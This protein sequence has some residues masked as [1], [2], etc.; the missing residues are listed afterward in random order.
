MITCMV[1]IRQWRVAAAWV[2]IALMMPM[3]GVTQHVGDNFLFQGLTDINPVSARAEAMGNAYT[4]VPLDG[5]SF[6]WNP[7]ALATLQNLSIVAQHAKLFNGLE[8]H[9]I[10]TTMYIS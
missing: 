2:L 3:V 5:Y 8:H 1:D 6:Y 4:A 9:N 10:T 7:A